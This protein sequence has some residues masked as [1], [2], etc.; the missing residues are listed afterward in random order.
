MFLLFKDQINRLCD[1]NDNSGVSTRS[2]AQDVV[3]AAFFSLTYP[4]RFDPS[5][6]EGAGEGWRRFKVNCWF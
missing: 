4:F 3:F 6:S 5:L 2:V 1:R